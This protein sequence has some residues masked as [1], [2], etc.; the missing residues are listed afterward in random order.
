MTKELVNLNLHVVLV[1]FPLALFLDGLVIELFSF[2]YRRS[3]A[4]TAER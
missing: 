2:I 4:Q 3:S 1:H